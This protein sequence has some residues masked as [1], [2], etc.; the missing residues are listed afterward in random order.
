MT[1]YNLYQQKCPSRNILAGISDKW[2]ILIIGLLA[3][4]PYRFGELKRAVSGIS[5]KVLTQTLI[6]L[7]AHHIILRK[8]FNELP[9]RVEYSLTSLGNELHEIL[10][11]LTEWTLQHMT[12]LMPDDQLPDGN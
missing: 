9:L 7:E 3:Q 12:Q 10:H 1:H 6:K 4:K 11:R 8:D 5:A 2:S